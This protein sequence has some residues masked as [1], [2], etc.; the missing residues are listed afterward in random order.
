MPKVCTNE[1][2][3]S[4]HGS[5]TVLDRGD[6]FSGSSASR[7]K[8]PAC[9]EVLTSLTVHCTKDGPQETHPLWDSMYVSPSNESDECNAL[10]FGPPDSHILELAE[11]VKEDIVIA[12]VRGLVLSV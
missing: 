2:L 7:P 11:S 12:L 1:D 8:G 3:Q 9:S 10:S 5:P 6:L 4:A